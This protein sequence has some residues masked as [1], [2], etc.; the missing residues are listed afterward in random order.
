MRKTGI[1]WAVGGLMALLGQNMA[2]ADEAP[3]S[4]SE[5]KEV[6]DLIREHAGGIPPEELDRAATKGLLW[7]LKPKVTLVTNDTQKAATAVS[8]VMRSNLFEG[9]IAYVRIGRVGGDLPKAVRAACDE[10]KGTNGL[11]GVVLDLRY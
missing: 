3:N 11:K 6:Y 8:P 7:A 5:F 10:I 1:L 4:N 2:F 9:N